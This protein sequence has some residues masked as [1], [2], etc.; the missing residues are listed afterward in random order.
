MT[1]LPLHPFLFA[2]YPVAAML[3]FNAA[4]VRLGDGVRSFLLALLL[5]SVLFLASRL[6][7]RDSQ[8]AAM[9]TTLALLLLFSYGHVYRWFG[10]LGSLGD[11]LGRHRYL[12]PVWVAVMACGTWM[13]LR[14]RVDR[15]PWTGAL[16]VAAL[17]LLILPTLQIAAAEREHR[18]A[19]A[20]GQTSPAAECELSPPPGQTPPD[21]YYII[22]DGY[23]RQ[24]VLANHFGFDNRPFLDELE[25]RGFYVA[26]WSQSNYFTT[27]LSLAS[28]LS[29]E[30]LDLTQRQDLARTASR[31]QISAMRT[32]GDVRRNLECLGYTI[33]ALDSSSPSSVWRDADIFLSPE[34]RGDQTLALSG[35]NGFEAMLFDSTAGLILSDAS[36]A[37]PSSLRPDTDLPMREH[38]AR[39]RFAFETLGGGVPAVASPKFVFAHILAPHTPY[40]FGPDGEDVDPGGTYTLQSEE[41][42]ADTAGYLNNLAFVNAATLRAVDGILARSSRPPVIILQSDHGAKGAAD[43]RLA[44]L[45]AFYFPGGEAGDLYPTITPV[46]IFRIAFNRY[47]GGRYDRL[48]D[49]SYFSEEGSYSD[50]VIVPNPHAAGVAP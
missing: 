36:I 8:R 12:I 49:L 28:S 32:H 27:Q 21:I 35:M 43:V 1:R 37:I 41:G 40:A 25:Q 42:D 38:R 29:Y 39:V 6:V 10:S 31:E 11:T 5:A 47:L 24:D 3:A 19:L 13:I 18:G 34:R 2:L 4:D 26:E 45:S 48:P 14:L 9:M 30:Y 22:L 7:V 16:N 33:V 15:A 44:N 50:L 23:A 17:V 46:N 20:A